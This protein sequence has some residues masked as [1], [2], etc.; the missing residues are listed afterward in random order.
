MKFITIDSFEGLP[1]PKGIDALN[2]YSSHF[3]KGQFIC[4][5]DGFLQNL[6][7]NGVDMERVKIVKGWFDQTLLSEKRDAYEI[8][9]IATVWID[10]DLYESTVPVLKFITPYLTTGSVIIFDDWRCYRNYPD[11]GEQR[12]CKEWLEMNPGIELRELLSFG[13]HGQAFTVKSC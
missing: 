4:S 9:K 13:W 2:G 7:A 6:K 3:Y 1:E 8:E 5:K 11:Y 10:C 12:A